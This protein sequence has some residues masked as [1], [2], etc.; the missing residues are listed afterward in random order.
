MIG[1]KKGLDMENKY[2][3]ATHLLE[4]KSYIIKNNQENKGKIEELKEGYDVQI[5]SIDA[6]WNHFSHARRMMPRYS[7]VVLYGDGGEFKVVVPQGKKVSLEDL[8]EKI[9]NV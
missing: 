7:G 9:G 3:L 5:F 4:G 2:Y 6:L 1:F 8:K